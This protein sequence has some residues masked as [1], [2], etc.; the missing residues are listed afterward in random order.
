VLLRKVEYKLIK[1]HL[2]FESKYFICELIVYA[3]ALI[4]GYYWQLMIAHK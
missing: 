2:G 4:F 1:L 3:L